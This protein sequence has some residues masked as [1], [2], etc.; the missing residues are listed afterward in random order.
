MAWTK[1]VVLPDGRVRSFCSAMSDEEIARAIAY[2]NPPPPP[3]PPQ[4]S[5]SP[6]AMPL[7][8]PDWA[9]PVVPPDQGPWP[10]RKPEV[11]LHYA[12]AKEYLRK[13]HL[14][15]RSR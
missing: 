7:R 6:R 14:K 5:R 10:A 13:Q 1:K 12:A 4:L 9:P 3:P 15:G 8:A 2:E 11:I